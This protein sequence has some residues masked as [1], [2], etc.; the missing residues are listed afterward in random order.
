MKA[1]IIG[2]DNLPVVEEYL[3]ISHKNGFLT[4]YKTKD[5]EDILRKLGYDIN[6]DERD[7]FKKNTQRILEIYYPCTSVPG[8]VRSSVIFSSENPGQGKTLSFPWLLPSR[9]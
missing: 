4:H 7:V 6:N 3:P 5:Y 9:R 2:S 8:D 1:L